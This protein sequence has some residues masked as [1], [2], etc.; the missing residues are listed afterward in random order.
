MPDT[1]E[2]VIDL[3]AEEQPKAEEVKA[4]PAKEAEPKKEEQKAELKP[5]DEAVE[6]LKKQYEQLKTSTSQVA[7]RAEQLSRE[8]DD[9]LQRAESA[10][11]RLAQSDLAVIDSGITAEKS[12]LAEAKQAKIAALQAGDYDK[13]ADADEKIGLATAR[14]V[15]YEEAKSDLEA[16][17]KEPPKQ[18]QQRQEP[19]R[20]PQ[21]QFEAMIAQAS[22]KAKDW[23]RAHPEYVTDEKLNR[24]ANAAHNMAVSEGFSVDTPE[25]FDYC[26][27]FLGMKKDEPKKEEPKRQERSKPMASAPVSR[28]GGP[29]SGNLSATQVVLTPGEQRAATD[30]TLVWNYD[31]PKGAFKKGDAIGLREMA[32]RKQALEKQGAYDRSYTN[33]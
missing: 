8:R 20:Q 11:K 31:D 18:E 3:E 1:E 16:R 12:A 4:E 23:L 10:T 21:D 32:K 6:S 17:Q 15:R 5:E 7:A 19:Q 26:E 25:Y 14:I 27:R 29:A 28:E 13:V 22:P 2:L 33:Q 24:K 9:A 30:G